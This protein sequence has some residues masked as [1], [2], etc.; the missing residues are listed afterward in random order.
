MPPYL[1]DWICIRLFL[2]T[3]KKMILNFKKNIKYLVKSNY[4]VNLLFISFM[5]YFFYK[6]FSKFMILKLCFCI[7][8]LWKICSIGILLSV[9]LFIYLYFFFLAKNNIV[10]SH[11]ILY[12]IMKSKFLYKKPLQIFQLGSC[13]YNCF[14]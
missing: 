7:K 10:H 14:V 1:N 12:L 3:R 2:E 8:Y 9:Y 6:I 5:F 13:C 11:T 4:R